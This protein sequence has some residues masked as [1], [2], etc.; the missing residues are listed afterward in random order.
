MRLGLEVE[1]W[2]LAPGFYGDVVGLREPGRHFVA[3]EVG[4]ARQREAQIVV[5][6]GR[7]LVELVQLVFERAGLLHQRSGVQAQLL[8]R[9]HLLAQL[10]AAR[11]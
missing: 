9:T 3:R 10:V 5:E 6:L 8:Q 2:D 4:N 11:L 1:G 7:G